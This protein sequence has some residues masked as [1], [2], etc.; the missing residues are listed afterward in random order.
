MAIVLTRRRRV[1]VNNG[2][3]AAARVRCSTIRAFSLVGPEEFAA[4]CMTR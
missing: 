3:E 2:V 4:F 1:I